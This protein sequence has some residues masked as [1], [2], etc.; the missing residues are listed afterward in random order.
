MHSTRFHYHGAWPMDDVMLRRYVQDIAGLT[1][2]AHQWIGQSAPAISLSLLQVLQ[3]LLS[4]DAMLVELRHPDTGAPLV[5]AS[6]AAQQ[7]VDAAIRR[8]AG[9]RATLIIDG[10]DVPITLL[11]Y[12]LGLDGDIGRIVVGAHRPQFPTALDWLVLQA[13][14]NE[15]MSALHSTA[16]ELRNRRVAAELVRQAAARRHAERDVHLQHDLIAMI[17]HELR[18]PL[19]A[20]GGYIDLFDLDETGPL[21]DAQ[22][23]YLSRLRSSSDYLTLLVRNV[24]DYSRLS[25]GAMETSIETVHVLDVADG[26]MQLVWPQLRAKG[27]RFERSP[28]V[29][30]LDV[31]ADAGKLQQILVNLLTNAAKYTDAGGRVA[32]SWSADTAVVH[33]RVS[34]TGRGIPQDELDHVFEPFVRLKGSGYVDGAGL[35]LAIARQFAVAMNGRIAVESQFGEGSTFTLTLPRAERTSTRRES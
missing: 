23:Q 21:T 5:S 18:T 10:D 22:R 3:K 25:R 14:G 34:D 32:L 24:F 13:A 31:H 19:S 30:G 8:A 6:G 29:D 15:A 20:I 16:L 2:L 17:G 27:V 11:V 28:D 35:G 26:V 9:E 4:A 1:R 7:E 12:P 33:I